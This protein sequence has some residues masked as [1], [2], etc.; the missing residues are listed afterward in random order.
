[1]KTIIFFIVYLMAMWGG[2]LY[3]I[4]PG[5]HA[6]VIGNG[7]YSQAPTLENAVNDAKAISSKL[8]E[9]G[10][11]VIE[12]H[13]LAR[14][15]MRK[16]LRDF[17]TSLGQAN[18]TVALLFYAGHGIQQQG[19]NYLIPV[20]ADISKAYEIEDA[21]L[22]L[23][24]ILA[25]LNDVQ[26]QLSIV[27]LDACRNNPFERRVHGISRGMKVRGSGLAP[28]DSVQGTILSFATE[29]GN[30]AV[31]GYSGHSPYTSAILKHIGTP[32][33]SI[34][35]MLNQVGLTVMAETHG[36]QK[37]WVSSSPVPRFCFAGCSKTTDPVMI[38]SNTPVL[39]KTNLANSN[40]ITA[41]ETAFKKQS[42]NDLKAQVRLTPSQESLISTLFD[43]YPDI[44]INPT[45]ASRSLVM[46][47]SGK[48]LEMVISEATNE[49]GNHVIPSRRWSHLTFELRQE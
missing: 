35:D 20:D 30:V 1:M 29:P 46:S 32:N 13:D 41:I 42:L 36:E 47:D 15:G 8:R 25:S 16:A 48:T 18:N 6:L 40:I 27:M 33:L 22:K 34:Q 28:I 43:L 31:D 11:H 24:T 9:L 10:F 21:A 2:Q 5:L 38:A 26:P 17:N 23:R 12:R 39:P 37:P 45:S 7:H 44:T 19:E 4:T 49:E 3:A 14:S